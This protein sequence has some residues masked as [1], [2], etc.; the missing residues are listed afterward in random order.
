SA[1]G[2][3]IMTHTAGRSTLNAGYFPETADTTAAYGRLP[4]GREMRMTPPGAAP[5]ETRGD[6]AL[7]T[8]ACSRSSSCPLRAD[9]PF[10]DRVRPSRAAHRASAL[11]FA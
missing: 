2:S 10:T 4:E 5:G 8:R 6:S 1:S 7:A 3:V 11:L 9:I